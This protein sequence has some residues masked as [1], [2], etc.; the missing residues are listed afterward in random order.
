[1]SRPL[2]IAEAGVN[3]N[4]SVAI[5]LELIDVAQEVGA[6]IVKFQTFTVD[7]LVAEDAPLAPY[8]ASQ[9]QDHSQKEMLSKLALSNDDF[10]CLRDHSLAAGI[11][12]L[13]TAFDVL[14][15]EFL[16]DLGIKRIKIP[17]GEITNFPLLASASQAGLPVIMSTGMAT[18]GEIE[19]ALDVLDSSRTRRGDITLLHCTTA[20]PAP[21]DEVNMRALSELSNRFGYSVGY[22][23]HT[24]GSM[25]G[26]MAVTLG[27]TVIEKHL[28]L[29]RAMAGPDHSASLDPQGFR[30][31][32]R[33]IE[34]A[35]SMLGDG[36]KVPSE[37]ERENL[38]IA[39]KSVYFRRSKLAGTVIDD[40]DLVARRPGLGISPMEWSRIVGSTTTRDFVAGELFEW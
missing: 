12:F 10:I 6:D 36:V 22:S 20:Y 30:D 15:L 16:I 7:E 2:V 1:V 8:Q 9:T 23:D 18:L 32:V 35:C 3:H 17:S 13:S 5:A 33:D 31:F 25:A 26:V 27:A 4:G 40:S 37:S 19:D 14:S 21:I 28:T 11:E 34:A 29:D 39:R 24:D 38:P